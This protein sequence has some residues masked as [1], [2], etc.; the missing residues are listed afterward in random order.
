M[1]EE[2]AEEWTKVVIDITDA[3]GERFYAEVTREEA[4]AASARAR[5][6]AEAPIVVRG[7]SSPAP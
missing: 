6:E 3:H 1:P 2:P 4:E 5:E 7:P